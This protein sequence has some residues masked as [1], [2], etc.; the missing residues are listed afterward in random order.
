[1]SKQILAAIVILAAVTTGFAAPFAYEVKLTV[2][3]N[4]TVELKSFLTINGSPSELPTGYE[5]TYEV[6]IISVDGLVLFNQSFEIGF[7]SP[8]GRA[9]TGPGGTRLND[10]PPEKAEQTWYLPVYKNAALIQLYHY[11]K[12]IWEYKIQELRTPTIE[13][14]LASIAAIVLLA[15]LAWLFLKKKRLPEWRL[16]KQK[17][18]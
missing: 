6:R 15:A 7:V 10:T 4:D 5:N 11:D 18:R 1:M 8:A 3:K 2:Y 12:K 17:P 16:K 14:S 13:T 9:F